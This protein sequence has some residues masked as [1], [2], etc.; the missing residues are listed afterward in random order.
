MKCDLCGEDGAGGCVMTAEGLLRLGASELRPGER[1][2][3][4]DCI[5]EA[6]DEQRLSGPG[7]DE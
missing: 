4:E 5:A 3:C 2:A 7:G 1:W 6:A